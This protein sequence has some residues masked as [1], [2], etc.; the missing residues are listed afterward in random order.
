MTAT[1]GSPGLALRRPAQQASAPA[2]E[3]WYL[4]SVAC[5]VGAIEV[6]GRL[7]TCFTFS[8][9]MSAI[10]A[11]SLSGMHA[12]Q[13]ALGV[14]AHNIAN[15]GTAGFRRQTVTQATQASGGVQALV[16]QVSEPGNALE[17]DLVDQL[18][19]KHAFSANLAVFKTSDSMVGALLNVRA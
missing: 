4:A 13:T 6:K 12:A 1:A 17:T 14:S 16:G 5:R 8:S 2:D 11:I 9:I 18:R 3:R 7:L 10:S 15:L 19:A